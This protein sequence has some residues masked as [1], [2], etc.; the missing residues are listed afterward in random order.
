[1]N[2]D[3]D[4][5]AAR[6]QVRCGQR[7]IKDRCLGGAFHR[8]NGQG[9]KANGSGQ[10]IV[11][12]NLGAIEIDDRAIVP[13]QAQEQP[14]V[15][16]GICYSDR[17]AEIGRKVFVVGIG[18]VAHGRNLAITSIAELGRAAHP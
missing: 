13:N 15:G 3:G 5:V 16:G 12:I 10:H 4:A 14:A 9:I 7:H 11:A 17:F 6:Q 2:F 8:C 18:S 1:M